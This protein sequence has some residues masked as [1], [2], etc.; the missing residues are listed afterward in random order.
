MGQCFSL[1]LDPVPGGPSFSVPIHLYTYPK[2]T[3]HAWYK[4]HS[5]KP[6]F[7]EIAFPGVSRPVG[8]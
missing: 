5:G 2:S 1:T 7:Y 8:L 4:L 6:S 3:E